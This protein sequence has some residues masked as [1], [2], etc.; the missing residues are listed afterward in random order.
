M[1]SRLL[2]SYDFKEPWF[3]PRRGFDRGDHI[4]PIGASVMDSV[5]KAPTHLRCNDD[6]SLHLV[7]CTASVSVFPLSDAL[8]VPHEVFHQFDLRHRLRGWGLDGGQDG[9]LQ[10]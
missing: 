6:H 10:S 8:L 7:D 3:I 9:G 5:V 4:P 2:N 1:I